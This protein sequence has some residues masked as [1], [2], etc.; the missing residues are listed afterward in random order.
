MSLRR[1]VMTIGSLGRADGRMH[2]RPA[3]SWANLPVRASDPA[4]R[5]YQRVLLLNP[6][7]TLY[8][9][10]YP[11]CTYPLG[12]G[13]VAAVL[14]TY[15]YDVA[16][17]DVFAEGY[18]Q[19]QPVVEDERFVRYGLDDA[20]VLKAIAEFCPDVVGVSSIFS[21]QADNVHHLL[22]LVR[23]A[24][25]QA[26]TA[27]GGAHPR[28]FPEACLADD[29]L[30]VVLLGESELTFLLWIE[31]LNKSLEECELR[32]IAYRK[33]DGSVEIRPE[34]PLIGT[35]TA[36]SPALADGDGELDE[37]PFPAWH[38]Y[39][40]ERYF[41]LRAYQSPY[42]RGT[43]V[44]QIYTSR[45]CTAQ[46]TFCTTTNFWGRKLRRRS[47]ENIIREL[48][49]LKDRYGI[50]EF[51]VQDDNITN[52][53][54][55]ARELFRAFCKLEL[56]WATPQGTALW[57][58]DEELLDL[59]A[60]SGAYQVTFAIESGVQRVLRELIHK[61][62]NLAR[63]SHLVQYARSLG[64]HVHGFFIVG[65]P[66]MNGC[67]GETL[68]EMR[69][70]YQYAQ[71]TGFDSASFFTASPIVGSEL[72]RECVRQGFVDPAESLYKMSYKQG[73]INVPGLWAGEEVA[74]L[75]A[76]FN[77]SFNEPRVRAYTDLQWN[78]GQY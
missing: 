33:S 35:A 51:H 29:A 8:E 30:D 37:I 20:A 23:A 24:A 48:T 64:M 31:C 78:P 1:D 74:M 65:M 26:R 14:E 4:A 62:L 42:T 34:L 21:N 6:A 2:G 63:S 77:A 16:M 46:C 15:Q 59:M 72:L 41:E 76:E 17:I 57:R 5:R 49:V 45:G 71:D 11:R 55:H 32:G 25:P 39:N 52:D 40:M 60:E 67:D 13:Y 66:P 47:V 43:R 68:T 7:A 12:I 44:G 53:M 19:A 70:S 50:D 61:P 75:A 18:H 38:L 73:L 58:M 36:K 56:P 10:D 22:R 3:T 28:Y 69:Q 9:H 54:E 27:I